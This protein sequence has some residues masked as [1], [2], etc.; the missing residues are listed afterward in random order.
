MNTVID[1]TL[2]PLE[3]AN[4]LGMDIRTIRKWMRSGKVRTID[5]SGNRKRIL[6]EDLLTEEGSQTTAKITSKKYSNG[7][8]VPD[9]FD[10]VTTYKELLQYGNAFAD[11]HV[12]FLLLVG[13]PGSGK[14]RQLQASLT[15]KSHKW[16]DSHATKLALYCSVYEANNTHVVMDDINHF[17]RDKIACSLMKSLTQTEK[18]KNV[19]WESTSKVL[20]DRNIPTQFTTQSPICMIAN[21]WT[22]GNP[23]MAAV[24][25]R[26]MPVAF[27]PC[28]S[29]IHERVA[30]LRWADSEVYEFIGNNLSLIPQPSMRDYYNGEKYKL[31]GM[32]WRSKLLKIWGV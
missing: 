4:L 3:A 2:S 25:D 21:M 16:I 27:Y 5:L 10:L 6:K 9:G 7:F 19:C 24:Q 8:E 12:P 17:F 18:V 26:S 1:D 20:D 31:A 11:G 30:Q 23:D 22:A 14:S 32:D 28:A 29:E 15:G 13:S